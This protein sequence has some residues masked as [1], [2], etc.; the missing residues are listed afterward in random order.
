MAPAPESLLL[1]VKKSE[2]CNCPVLLMVAVGKLMTK[3]LVEVVM[4]KM[5]P[6]VPVETL[7]MTP[8]AK[9]MVVEV[10]IN[11]FCPP[12]ME[13]PEPTVRSPR[14]VVPI[15][16]LVT[17]RRPVMSEE[18]EDR[19]MA[20]VFSSPP[21]ALTTPVP[22]EERVVEPEGAMVKSDMPVWEAT[23]KGLIEP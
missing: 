7:E 8:A 11:T 23:A 4:L 22:N 15:P 10:P 13:S 12:T 16:P 3:L 1:K 21:T 6:A 2:P 14:V 20:P 9:L 5:L 17:E 18:P 19:L